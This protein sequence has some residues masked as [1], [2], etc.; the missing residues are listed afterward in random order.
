MI[1][2]ILTFSQIYSQKIKSSNFQEMLD[3]QNLSF[4]I[5]EGFHLEKTVLEYNWCMDGG[6][7]NG[8]L[9]TLVNEDKSILIGI[10]LQ[11]LESKEAIER[12]QKMVPNYDPESIF[13]DCIVRIMDKTDKRVLTYDQSYLNKFF[14]A[15][16][17]YRFRRA[18][19]NNYLNKYNNNK[20]VMIA[21]KGQG[22]FILN[23]LYSDD[24]KNIEKEINAF[25]PHILKFKNIK[26]VQ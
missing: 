20:I 11:P 26:I 19:T 7:T 2:G 8:I 18:C 13:N 14:N 21:K 5:P 6:I 23:V 24:V 15:D 17:G 4:S 16:K 9:E 12:I 3:Y 1:L 25:A 10:T 22:F